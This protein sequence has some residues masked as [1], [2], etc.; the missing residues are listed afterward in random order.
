MISN[1]KLMLNRNQFFTVI[2]IYLF[3]FIAFYSLPV[4]H[5]D[6]PTSTIIESSNGHL[7]GAKIADDGQWRF[8]ERDSL[9]IKYQQ[10]VLQ[11]EDAYFFS[12]PGVNPF[13]LVRATFQNLK[14]KKIVSGGSTISMQVVRLSRKGKERTVKQKIIEILLSL[15]LEAAKTKNEIFNLY[16]S[17]APFGGNIV[18]L[19]AASWRYFGRDPN[20]LSWAESATLAVLPN[21]P[22]LIYPGKSNHLLFE[23]RNQ[24]LLKLYNK[25]YIDKTTYTLSVQ[26]KLPSKP[27]PLPQFAPH[28]LIRAYKENKGERIRTTINYD[29]QLQADQILEKHYNYLKFNEIH[30]AAAIILEVETGNVIAYIGN[31]TYDKTN[32]HGNNV[33]IIHAERSTGSLLK[34]FLFSFMLDDAELLPNMLIPD[35]PTQLGSFSPKNF[36]LRYDGVVPAK[37]ALSRSLNVPAVLLLSEYGL[38]RFYSKLKKIG[39]STLH[40]PS[41]HYGLTIILGG[42]EG[43]LWDL[44]SMYN[45][46]S[47]TLNGYTKNENKYSTDTWRKPNYIL[48]ALENNRKN[49]FTEDNYL[50]SASAIWYTFTSLL[51]VNR[52][53]SEWGWELFSDS[54]NIAWKTGTSFGYRDAWAIGTNAKYSVGI[55]VGNADGEGRPGLTGSSVA[56][57]VLFDIF[58]ILENSDW[59]VKPLDE[60]TKV[61]I[62]RESGHRASINCPNVDTLE[63]PLNGL[64][65]K[66]CPY[67]KILHL[68]KTESYQVTSLCENPL[69]MVHKAWFVLPPIQEWFYKLHNPSYKTLPPFKEECSNSNARNM[70]F[71][72]P[73]DNISIYIPLEIDG[74]R[75]KV[76]F[77]VAHRVENNKIHWHLDNKYIGTTKKFHQ[78]AFF[79]NSGSHKMTLVDEDGEVLIKKFK[80]ID[81]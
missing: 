64:R 80:I 8:P 23:K 19:D 69:N 50:V 74:K 37:K 49:R 21:A 42:V 11:F 31:T 55:W 58:N 63:I 81:K 32:S 4:I 52:P 5:F 70:E 57:P 12:H 43:T 73:K 38:D 72:Y 7:L 28:L 39:F 75:G 30:N 48:T 17:N 9:P 67:H 60:I 78:M 29:I 44:T 62:C 1:L 71:I 46:F 76:V 41:D 2:A 24:L 54:E 36:N 53:D 27:N 22:S 66:P 65:T 45:N 47:R 61:P 59:F 33:D 40:K 51:E 10:A 18:G 15:R 77:E 16:A 6:D 26:E 14:N 34:P 35:I 20:Q 25:A 79:T 13:S 56:A 3:L 68:D